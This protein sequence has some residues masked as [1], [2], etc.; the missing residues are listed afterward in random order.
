MFFNFS[1]TLSGYLPDTI[2]YC[3][4]VP[5]TASRTWNNHYKHFYNLKDFEGG[6]IQNIMG[7][8]LSFMDIYEKTEVAAENGDFLT[9]VY[10]IARL[11]RRLMDFESM[12]RASL[13]DI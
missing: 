10:Q 11:I 5:G 4:F 9:V 2:Y 8:F 12:Q 7:N 6:F 3:Y 1:S 13:Q